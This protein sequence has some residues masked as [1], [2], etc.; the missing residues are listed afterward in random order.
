MS[1]IV[2]VR[3]SALSA[4]LF[5][6]AALSSG[7]GAPMSQNDAGSV[8]PWN[9]PPTRITLG[10][11]QHREQTVSY[12]DSAG[13]TVHSVTAPAGLTVTV[14]PEAG[15]EN[16]HWQLYADY[17]VSGDQQVLITSTNARGVSTQLTV[18]VTVNPIRWLPRVQW[19]DAT[20]P[21]AREHGAF[22]LD[23]MRNRL[24]LLGGSGY[25]PQ[26][27]A[28]SDAWSFDLVAGAWS[29]VNTSGDMLS[30]GASRRVVVMPDGQTAYLFGG[31]GSA[32]S[33]N[34]ELYRLSLNDSGGSVVRVEQRNP[35]PVRSLHGFGY[36]PMSQRFV[37]F[38]GAG[39]RSPLDDT[40][41]MTLDNGV[42]V[43]TSVDVLEAPTA[44]Y[45]FFTAMDTD[46]GRFIVFSGAQGF[47]QIDA[48]RDT[49]AL[50]V[51]STPPAWHQ[52][53]TG[54]EPGS[55]PG[56]RNGVSV[57]DPSGPRLWVIGG[58]ADARTTEAGLWAFDALPGAEKWTRVDR[59][60]AA[61]L[62]SSAFGVYDGARNRVVFGF[63]NS[64]AGVF[65]DL[66]AF[67]Y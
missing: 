39:A 11:G 20:G 48:A 34:N 62:R 1:S 7:C 5:L 49:W 53:A 23:A 59:E 36:D 16:T 61:P 42:A 3:A 2:T 54:D 29:M 67:G 38:G 60:G 21:S 8:S 50:D 40:W 18:T 66:A 12:R 13:P 35:P 25:M 24:L 17:T 6:A 57:W 41:M 31:Y 46:R 65:R 14:V 44:R 51:R 10:Q 19:T 52:L 26:G 63:G 27:M 28:L 58:T 47:A 4:W 32:N 56:R 43:W 55:P 30:G 9:M 22:V 64:L 37:V 15:S 33:M 45:G